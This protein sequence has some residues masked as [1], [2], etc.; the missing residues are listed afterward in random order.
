ME[1]YFVKY[2]KINLLE[3]NNSKG[4]RYNSRILDSTDIKLFCEISLTVTKYL[5]SIFVL[6]LL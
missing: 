1:Q 4:T 6:I 3:N 2:N 5:I